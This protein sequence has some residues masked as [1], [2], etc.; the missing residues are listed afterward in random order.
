MNLDRTPKGISDIVPTMAVNTDPIVCR[1][2]LSSWKQIDLEY[3]MALS[4][5]RC[6][7]RSGFSIDLSR[8]EFVFGY[9]LLRSFK[10]ESES[11]CRDENIG[12]VL[13]QKV[14]ESAQFD[15]R[16]NER[17]SLVGGLN[18]LLLNRLKQ[19]NNFLFPVDNIES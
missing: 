5:R 13:H 11:V 1:K 15:L 2:M 17:V 9:N 8:R 19:R 7:P 4:Y 16:R 18:A 3:K 6:Q 10:T 14:F 12:T